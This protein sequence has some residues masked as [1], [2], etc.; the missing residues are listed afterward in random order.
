MRRS[1]YIYITVPS[2]SI[3]ALS[4]NKEGFLKGD[5]SV[6]N[7]G[8][9][10]PSS[11]IFSPCFSMEQTLQLWVCLVCVLSIQSLRSSEPAFL[12]C[13]QAASLRMPISSVNFTSP[14]DQIISQ[15]GVENLNEVAKP[16]LGF[17]V[18][19]ELSSSH[20]NHLLYLSHHSARI[21]LALWT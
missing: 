21:F 15:W 5:L 14:P 4:L 8:M 19:V 16:G 9:W 7:Y 12:S 20:F 11:L 6:F 17:S 10:P 2:F 1:M 13:A 18:I 3:N